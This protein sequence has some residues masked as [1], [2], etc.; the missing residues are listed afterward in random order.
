[1]SNIFKVNSRFASLAEDNKRVVYNDDKKHTRKM[2]DRVVNTKENKE[3][4]DKK[5]IDFLSDFHFPTLVSS[6]NQIKNQ[7]EDEATITFLDKLKINNKEEIKNNNY[8]EPGCVVIKL[9]KQKRTPVFSYGEMKE[10]RIE[11]EINPLEVLDTLVAL[12]EQ[13]TIDYINLWGYD[14]YEKEFLFPNYDYEYFDKLDEAME[15]LNIEE[16]E[17]EEEEDEW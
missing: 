10:D 7:K 3:R 8:I 17:K 14:D 2:N 11:G 13:R 4:I 1:M 9:D 16:R 6:Q 5:R 12:H 15:L